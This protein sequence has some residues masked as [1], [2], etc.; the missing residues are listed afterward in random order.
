M[1]FLVIILATADARYLL[2][3]LEGKVDGKRNSYYVLLTSS[4][5]TVVKV[6]DTS[7]YGGILD[8]GRNSIYIK[9]FIS[10]GGK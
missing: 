10:S 1:Y 4:L 7:I 9:Y 2:V 3:N 5:N 8:T 6:L